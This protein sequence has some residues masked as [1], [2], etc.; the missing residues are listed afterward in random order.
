[1]KTCTNATTP[2]IV[3]LSLNRYMGVT[4]S[5][6]GS[7]Q[8]SMSRIVLPPGARGPRTMHRNAETVIMVVQGPFTT[9][10]GEKGEKQSSAKPAS[11]CIFQATYGA[12]E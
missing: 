2:T 11:S 1:L 6:A 12:N 8:L 9:L 4:T 7:K 3:P 10:M 5:N